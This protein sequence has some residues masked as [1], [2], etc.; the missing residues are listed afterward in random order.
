MKIIIM[1]CILFPLLMVIFGLLHHFYPS[2]IYY[3][4]LTGIGWFGCA[5]LACIT[6]VLLAFWSPPDP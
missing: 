2:N 6:C 1:L 4:V 5:I 3:T